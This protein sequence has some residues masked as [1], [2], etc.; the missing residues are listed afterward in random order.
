[1]PQVIHYRRNHYV[2]Q[3]YQRQFLP[4]GTTKFFYLDKSPEVLSRNGHKWTR[5]AVMNWGPVNCFYVDDLYTIKLGK[6]T[7][8]IV[9][10][11]FFGPIDGA[12]E[13]A[14]A[15]FRQ[16]GVREGVHAA[17]ENLIA[18]MDIQ[19]FRTPRGLDFIKTLVSTED[20]NQTL[21]W[22]RQIFRFH[23]TMWTEGV[24]EIVQA[25]NSRTKFLVT[26]CPVTFYNSKSFPGGSECQYPMD[27]PLE[28]TGT[29]TLFPLSLNRCLI[30]SH[31]QLCRNPW[32]NPKAKRANARAYQ[33]TM[34]N[35]LDVQ[36]DR[37]LS[38]DEVIRINLI[39]KQKATRYIAAA[40]ESWLYPEQ[41]VRSTHWSKID[42][43]WF[44]FPNLYK[45]PFTGEMVVGYKDG[46][47]WAMDEYGRT[48]RH[49]NYRDK[50]QHQ[51][52]WALTQK[53][54]LAWALK[55]D[56][57]PTS[58]T[59]EN[60]FNSGYDKMMREDVERHKTSQKRM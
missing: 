56:G 32:I 50:A 53:A 12:A 59:D 20:Q 5:R 13:R 51:E 26:D 36:T 14:V 42:D 58:Q 54:K 6:Q 60:R 30:I 55:R 1:M 23:Q 7:L 15:F 16:F 8:D 39:L 40:D 52:E 11:N 19:R 10:K 28:W 37:N 31:L 9:E 57:K 34:M 29:R 49:P 25:D 24:W 41:A 22:M 33:N 2:A 44:L 35:F 3:W 43:D 45:V 38:E 21:Y 18:Y 4:T 27:T 47:S 46:S 48:A 17:F